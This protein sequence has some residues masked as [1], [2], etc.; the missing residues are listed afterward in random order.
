MIT[1]IGLCAGE[2][3]KYLDT[4]DGKTSL[5]SLLAE[6]DAPRETILMAVGWL[7]REGHILMRGSGLKDCRLELRLSRKES[8]T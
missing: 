3:W 7:A 5:K 6:I 2:V 4:H 1:W 8:G